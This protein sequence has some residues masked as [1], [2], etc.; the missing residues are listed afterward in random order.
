MIALA[1]EFQAVRKRGQKMESVEPVTI[2]SYPS[3]TIAE[4]VRLRL[5]NEGFSPFLADAETIDMDWFLDN[6]IGGIKVQVP[7]AEADRA[8][9][10][11]KEIERKIRQSRWTRRPHL[12]DSD[13]SPAMEDAERVDELEKLVFRLRLQVATLFRFLEH[14]RLATA[15]E[16]RDLMDKIDAEDGAR[17]EEFY[18]DMIEGDPPSTPS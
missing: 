1:E 2:A 6:A 12:R 11:L 15:D 14:K 13:D 17:D 18:G 4:A 3:R 16:L 7:K 8:S 9:A 5:E 10:T